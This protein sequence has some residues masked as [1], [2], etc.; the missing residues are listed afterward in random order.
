MHPNCPKA[1]NKCQMECKD[2]NKDC[3]A[4]AAQG[5][6]DAN[7]D[8]MLAYCVDSCLCKERKKCQDDTWQCPHWASQGHCGDATFAAYMKLMCKKS[9]HYCK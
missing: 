3:G 5:E 4:W 2:Y 7:P 6:C 1:C 8:Y 9:C